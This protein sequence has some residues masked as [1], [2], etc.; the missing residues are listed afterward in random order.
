[1]IEGW[2]A[3]MC[4]WD[5]SGDAC[6]LLWDYALAEDSCFPLLAFCVVALMSMR[7]VIT[8]SSPNDVQAAVNA[9][10]L[11]DEATTL[12]V[13]PFSPP[14]P[15]P[16][17]TRVWIAVCLMFLRSWWS[18]AGAWS[19]QLQRRLNSRW[20]ASGK[21]LTRRRMDR[22]RSCRVP[23]SLGCVVVQ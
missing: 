18:A 23:C 20:I 3:A 10:A 1:M 16:L 4:G 17:H 11:K 5:S 8:T 6:A 13:R 14:F 22:C 2:L 7:H 19:M 21:R 9:F 15:F 12:Q